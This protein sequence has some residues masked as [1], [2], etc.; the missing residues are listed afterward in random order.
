MLKKYIKF[1]QEKF[2]QKKVVNVTKKLTVS[3]Y[4]KYQLRSIKKKIIFIAKK[5]NKNKRVFMM[6]NVSGDM[7]I[8]YKGAYLCFDCKDI[9]NVK[10]SIIKMIQGNMN[11]SCVICKADCS[12]NLSANCGR[13]GNMC[14]TNCVN[15]LC[16][17]EQPNIKNGYIMVKCP[18]C[19]KEEGI[20]LNVMNVLN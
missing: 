16:S 2:Y 3:N 12:V 17:E 10:P 19:E 14:C 1:I 11:H 6:R 20:K 9:E 7:I 4:N 13:C 15:K 18:S 5:N 8:L